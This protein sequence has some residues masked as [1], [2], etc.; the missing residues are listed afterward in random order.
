MGAI[1]SFAKTPGGE[2]SARAAGYIEDAI[3]K[4][5]SG[6]SAADIHQF[7]GLHLIRGR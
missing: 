3:V 4:A 7:Y 1:R 5:E 2:F 6:D